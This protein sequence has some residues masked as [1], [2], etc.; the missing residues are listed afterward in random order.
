MTAAL[1]EKGKLKLELCTF[2]IIAFGVTFL[3]EFADIGM[4]GS[5]MLSS[6]IPPIVMFIPA[7]AA[8]SCL[9]YF[10]ST[11]LTRE[12]KMFLGLF[13]ISAGILIFEM[14]FF[15]ILGTVGPYPILSVVTSFGSLALVF[16][17]NLK[18]KWRTNL[19]SAKLSFGKNRWLYLILSLIFSSV[20]ISALLI[21]YFLGLSL[22]FGG[23]NLSLFFSSL[24]FSLLT[25]VITWPVYFGEEY[26][27]RFYLQDR[28]FALFGRYTGVVLIGLIWGLWHA[29]MMLIGMN[30]PN[31]SFIPANA[32]Y[33]VYTIIMSVVFGYAVLKTGSIWIAVLLHALTDMIVNA[34]RVS[35]SGADTIVSFLPVVVIL[36]VMAFILLRSKV[37]TNE[38]PTGENDPVIA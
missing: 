1:P 25:L 37:W 22:P 11:A 35:I 23:F 18:G 16:V 15:P 14:V 36:G 10:K 32:V 9:V 31:E 4:Y 5:E 27:W 26:G 12:A 21:S 6:R 28:M 3:L 38:K 19:I 8:I 2:L 24:G 13:V 17:L 34:G 29:P 30:F 20:Y 33:L 7:I